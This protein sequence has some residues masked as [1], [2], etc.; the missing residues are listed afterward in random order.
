MEPYVFQ[1]TKAECLDLPDKTYQ[2]RYV[3]CTGEQRRLYKQVKDEWYEEN[4]QKLPEDMKILQLFSRLQQV[5]CGFLN[6]DAERIEVAHRRH[7]VLG[8]VIDGIGAQ[9][10]IVWGKFHYDIDGICDTLKAKGL[11]F[12]R[13]DGRMNPTER[14][15][16]IDRFR[17]DTQILVMTQGTGGMGLTLNE[18]SYV[19]YYSNTFK[20]SDRIQSEDRCHRIGQTKKVTYVD[21]VCDGTIDERIR[22]CL[23]E[24]KGL[25][26]DFREKLKTVKTAKG[27][28]E[29]LKKL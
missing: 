25:L 23:G 21:I 16:S 3:E 14:Q 29:L 22:A 9:K 17:G 27:L 26:E 5:A 15:E 12:A 20:Y 13:M 19:I 8:S 24:K 11:S 10:V 7:E 1:I 6:R 4:W 18:A 28:K 2:V